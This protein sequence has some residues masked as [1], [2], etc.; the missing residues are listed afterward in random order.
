MKNT[1]GILCVFI[2]SLKVFA[3]GSYTSET[4]FSDSFEEAKSS[5]IAHALSLGYDGC[6]SN[7]AAYMAG[8]WSG[9][10]WCANGQGGVYA[11]GQ[12]TGNVDFV[13]VHYYFPKYTLSDYYGNNHGNICVGNPINPVSGSKIQKESLISTEGIQPI[14]LDLYYNS[15]NLDK[16]RHSYSRSIYFS[17]V[18]T[19][20]R[21]D[22]G[23]GDA[24]GFNP[25]AEPESKPSLGG[26]SLVYGK[27]NLA[28]R[29]SDSYLTKQEACE[30][31]WS[32]FKYHYKYSWIN[33]SV[34]EYRLTPISSFGAVGQCYILDAPDGNVKMVLDIL[35]LFSGKPGGGIYEELNN[36]VGNRY[37]RFNRESGDVI[38]FS[39]LENYKN[40]SKTGETLSVLR[41]GTDLTYKLHT[42]KDEIEEY[43]K[44]GKLL[45]ITSTQGHVQSLT[46]DA[47]TGKLSQVSSQTG[48]SLTF[49]YED[50]GD[51][52]QYSRIKTITDHTGRVW[53]FN[54]DTVSH[55]LETI[56]IPGGTSRQYHYEDLND[57][58]LLTGITDETG[59]RYATWT[60]NTD[61]MATLSAHGASQ[62]KGRI[63]L[64]YFDNAE[65][66]MRM[67]RVKRTTGLTSGLDVDIVSTYKTHTVSGSPIVAEVT[68]VNPIKYEHNALTGHLEYK[69]EDPGTAY[70]RHTEYNNYDTKGNPGTIKEAVNTTDQREI[71]YTFDSRYHSKV[72]TITETSVYLGSSKVTTNQYDDFGNNTSVTI[73]G[74]KPDGTPVSR[75]TVFTYD[76]PF[77]QLTQIDGPRTDVSD[78]YTIDYYADDVAESD[79]RARMKQVSAPLGITLYGN[80]T[81]TPTG[82]INT[83]IDANNVQS[84]MS[85]YN[86]NDR[87]QSLSQFDLNTG[88]ERLTEWTYRAT[89][90]VE[91]ITTGADVADKTILTFNYDDARRLT[92]IVDGLGN[93]IEYILDSEGNVEQENIRDNGGVLK[94]QL[95]QT[96]DDY[97]RLKLRTQVNERFTETWSPNGTLDKTV[98]GKSVTTD[99]NYDNLRRLTEINQDMGGSSPQTANALTTLNYDL[100][101]NLTYVKNPVNGETIY[102]YDDLGNQLTRDSDD[103]G[104]TTYTYDEAGNITSMLDANGETISYTYD[105]MNRLTSVTTSNADDDYQYEYDNC[106]NGAGRLCKVSNAGNTQF[107]QY[108]AFGNVVSQQSLQYSYDTANRLETIS[109]PSGALVRYDYDSAGQVSQVTLERNG[110]SVPLAS[111]IDYEAFGDITNLLYGNTLTLSQ[112]RDSAYRPLTQS[113]LSVIE[114]NYTLYDEN[115]NLTQRDDAIARTNSLFG[116]DAHNRL[117]MASD[118][119]SVRSYEYD[120][121][122]NRTKLTEDAVSSSSSYDPASNRLSMRG[123][124]NA[125]LD[126]NGNM[127]DLGDRS[128]SYSKHNRLFEV[129]DN[130]VL[131]ATYQYNGL[132][133]RI[134]K[135]LADGAGK[136]FIYD[137]DGKLMTETDINGNVL[138]EY[139]Y[140]NGQLLA[141]YTPDSDSDGISN[142][143]ESVAG[144]N[145][146]ALDSDD[147]G[148]TDLVEMFVHGTSVSNADTDDDGVNDSQEVA[149]NSNPLDSNINLGDVNLNG[150][151]NVGDYVVLMQFVLGTRRPTPTEELQADI[152]HDG[153]LNVQDMLLMQRVMFGLQVSWFDITLDTIDSLF[154][155]VY[156]SIIP[157]AYA[158]NGDGD[159]Y[160]VHNDH[161]GTPVKMTNE[162][163]L[164]VWQATYDPFGKATVDE[165][166][167]GDGNAVEMNVR[168]PGQY[169]DAESGLHYNYFRTYD[170]ELGRYITSDPI[171]LFGGLNTFG[172][173]YGNPMRYIDSY[174]LMGSAGAL[175][176]LGENSNNKQEAYNS[177]MNNPTNENLQK[178]TE[179][180]SLTPAIAAEAV[181]KSAEAYYGRGL[182]N[183]LKKLLPDPAKKVPDPSFPD[184]KSSDNN[185]GC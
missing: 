44:E 178:W 162:M 56:D 4:Y 25:I 14:M 107:Y 109:Y 95:T 114:L 164:V 123:V 27:K 64:G 24:N 131:K 158:T 132:G 10:W 55:T 2:F 91:T 105:A 17:N 13:F 87:L 103:T 98:D 42:N 177:Y 108:D 166:V 159:I 179:A 121:N 58:Q 66:G 136:Y 90:E 181:K 40:I 43:S 146:T 83:Y 120:K 171:G 94:K 160:Y 156:Q 88:E 71:S 139:I 127:L 39:E 9:G 116:F 74:F 152:N 151:F 150:E 12:E 52:N 184:N 102:T 5:C 70:Q 157:P 15:A 153:V 104:L 78:I 54:Y 50:F 111:N 41:S 130:G 6:G 168:F 125:V 34:A 26:V 155:Q 57:L 92:S 147:D 72:A 60:Y 3:A 172:Y 185:G 133:Q 93:T 101:D 119:F 82:K 23:Y 46:Y 21:Y 77:H 65:R 110:S 76:G 48:G 80:I 79:N 32:R 1:I 118:E 122:D 128:Y 126:S 81:Y 161:L 85:Y 117:N 89:G 22:M 28:P 138:F 173:V 51:I 53:S 30:H 129:F 36:G 140:L 59:T 115:G 169:Y 37:L 61:G 112:S 143:E 8:V 137:T 35:E 68:G 135:T 31:G 18:P 148:L 167:D 175:K 100:Q 45:S 99:Y 141:K 29:D 145:P 73:D 163:G 16:W 69:I 142:Y 165:D 84:T 67:T 20:N 113:I 170:P 63:E 144:T 182:K 183:A 106:Q 124:D 62:D 97:N 174:G 86:G 7:S 49:S 149:F 75:T 134:N 11:C 19:G 176:D 33:G 154:A 47:V 180:E 96:F 38:V